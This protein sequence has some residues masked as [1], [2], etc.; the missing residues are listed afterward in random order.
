MHTLHRKP[1]SHI[2]HQHDSATTAYKKHKAESMIYLFQT[3]DNQEFSWY[4]AVSFKSERTHSNHTHRASGRQ[5]KVPVNAASLLKSASLKEAK[6]LL[7][8]DWRTT[9]VQKHSYATPRMLLF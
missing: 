5:L 2:H 4:F 6:S 1:Q 9:L 3:D 8:S 7:N